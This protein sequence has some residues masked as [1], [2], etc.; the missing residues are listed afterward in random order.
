[1]ERSEG[2]DGELYPPAPVPAHERVW[3]H[4]SEVGAHAWATTEPPMVL[5]RR[6]G[7]VTGAVGGLLA[8]AVLWTLLPTHAGRTAVVSVRSTVNTVPPSTANLAPVPSTTVVRTTTPPTTAAEGPPPTYVVPVSG[9]A[10]LGDERP[11]AIAVAIDGAGLLVTLVPE[12][13]PGG[14]LTVRDATGWQ[15]AE[16]LLHDPATGLVVLSHEVRGNVLEPTSINPGDT[17][18]PAG[19]PEVAVVV[20][21]DGSV[22]LSP[23]GAL[24]GLRNGSPI[25]NQKGQ[26]AALLL[27][28]EQGPE[29]VPVDSLDGLRNIIAA[30]ATER[31]WMGVTMAAGDAVTPTI[32]SLDAEGPA[33]AAG[34][35]PGDVIISVDHA[36]VCDAIAVG[37]VLAD[38]EPGD[39]VVVIV[40]RNG[41]RV[42]HEVVLG[43]PRPRV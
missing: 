41:E 8:L 25:L 30:L 34:L 5:G 21:G 2:D 43:E 1:M 24:T 32:E 40:E 36:P 15:W 14:S 12:A 19:H 31:V 29:L 20:A 18:S 7:A 10:A 27:W 17:L 35:Q 22:D 28:R 37:V 11:S 26:L 33:A 3:R 38:H 23:L 16:V 13:Q 4:P 6:L 9:E 42:R 39:T